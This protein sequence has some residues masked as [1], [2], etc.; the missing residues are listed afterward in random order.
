MKFGDN[1]RKL[2]KLKK[3]SQEELAEKVGVSRQSVSKWETGDAYPEMN[4]ILE[5]CKIFKCNIGELVNDNMIDLDSLD[6]D[7]KMSIVKLKKEEQTKIKRL[8][9]IIEAISKIGSIVS[10]VFIPILI[11]AIIVLPFIVNGLEVKDNKLVGVGDFKV[12]Y[13]KE[14]A[15]LEYKN[16][17]IGDASDS[18]KE[19]IDKIVEVYN[20]HSKKKIIA[21]AE[22]G[23]VLIIA[24]LV[25]YILIFGSLSKLFHNI[26]NGDTPFTMENADY[27]EKIAK[28]MIAAIIAS[29]IGEGIMEA[30]YT[31]EF[32]MGISSIDIVEIL[33]LFAMSYIF[34]YGYMIQQDS[35]GVMYGGNEDE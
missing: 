27:I 30:L 31:S 16:N 6:E 34:K 8:S 2:R 19:S 7:V 5:L 21:T 32:T 20:N 29:G 12:V 17:R 25:V 10:K 9:K 1:L 26:N 15:Y 4:N 22:T 13:E 14:S 28:L 24:N 23:M 35:E 33:F 11:I 18:D 3:I